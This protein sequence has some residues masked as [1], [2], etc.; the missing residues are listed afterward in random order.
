VSIRSPLGISALVSVLALAVAL[1]VLLQRT[2]PAEPASSEGNELVVS[3]LRELRRSHE[4]TAELLERIEARLAQRLEAPP[5]ERTARAPQ[6][7][8]SERESFDELAKS[9]DAL[10]DTFERESSET[11]AVIRRSPAFGGESLVEARRRRSDVDWVALQDLEARWRS[12]PGLAN[13]SQYFQ[14][15]HDLLETYG[16]PTAIYRPGKGGMLLH[17]RRAPEG[18]LGPSWYFKLEDGIVVEFF[19]EDEPTQAP[20]EEDS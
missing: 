15:L 1:A 4:R 12:E 6:G 18:T 16:P 19:L 8:L 14:T 5:A 17:Y 20:S 10:R 11:Q 2:R 9:L 13:R 3:E 7:E